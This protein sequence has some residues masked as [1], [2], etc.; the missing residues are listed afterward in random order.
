LST[1][2]AVSVRCIVSLS[3][4]QIPAT[5]ARL[6]PRKL[7]LWRGGRCI[8]SALILTRSNYR[9]INTAAACCL[10]WIIK[11]CLGSQQTTIPLRATRWLIHSP[12]IWVLG[13]KIST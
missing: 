3:G 13:N 5:I 12:P 10:C 2:P 6:K 11:R 4:W 8:G 9:R 7:T 1:F